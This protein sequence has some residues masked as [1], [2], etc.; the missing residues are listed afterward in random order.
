M[1]RA[2]FIQQAV[3]K[4]VHDGSTQEHAIEEAVR[5][6]N[7]LAARKDAE[8]SDPSDST[9]LKRIED[10]AH[11]RGY[12]LGEQDGRQYAAEEKSTEPHE[13]KRICREAPIEL[14]TC[15]ACNS[16]T[17]NPTSNRCECGCELNPISKMVPPGTRISAAERERETVR[18]LRLFLNFHRSSFSRIHH[19]E[20]DPLPKTE[21]EVDSFIARRTRLWRVTWLFPLLDDLDDIDPE[22]R[23]RAAADPSFR[24]SRCGAPIPLGGEGLPELCPACCDDN[25]RPAGCE[26]CHA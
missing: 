19:G 16:V 5:L 2:E 17:I 1:T 8:W 21:A 26:H 18:K 10:E 11:R 7:N 9:L 12:L 23:R 25:D 22:A 15:T 24:C 4:L 13:D 14:A 6:A 3:L 20:D